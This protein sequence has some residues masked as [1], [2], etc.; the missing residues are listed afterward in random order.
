MKIIN[1]DLNHDLIFCCTHNQLCATVDSKCLEYLGYMQCW[2]EGRSS[3]AVAE[4]LRPTAT[5]TVA[6]VLGHSYGRRFLLVVFLGSSKME[7]EICFSLHMC[8][9]RL[10]WIMIVLS[11][12][13]KTGPFLMIFCKIHL[14]SWNDC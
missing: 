2:T 9:L 8:H 7:A 3:T 5:A 11:L 10:M 14:F 12:K 13:I 6:E 4:D 1:P